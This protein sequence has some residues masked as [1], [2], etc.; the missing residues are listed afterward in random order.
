MM[1]K[2]FLNQFAGKKSSRAFILLS[3]FTLFGFVMGLNQDRFRALTNNPSGKVKQISAKQ[4]AQMLQNKNFTLINVH[5]PY[6][7][8]IE[9]TDTLIRYDELVA[10]SASLPQDK[11]APIVL[12]CKTGRMSEEAIR[13]LSKL[14]FTNVT[15]LT[16]GMDAWQKQGGKLLDLSQIDTDVLPKDGVELPI[17]WGNLGPQLVSLGV[18]DL[19]KFKDLVKPTPD[20]LTILMGSTDKNIKIDSTNSQFVVD[21]L[22]A[23][24]L[25]QKSL[26]YET[27]PMGTQYKKDVGNFA[28]TGGW[29]LSQG[30]AVSHLNQHDII[31]LTAAQQ[32]QVAQIA[33]NIYRPCCGN[34]TWFP[35]CNHGMAALALIEVMV[36]NNIDEATIYRK[37]LGFNSFWFPTSYLS[38]ATY[39]ARLG[40]PWNQVDTKLVLSEEY[41]SSKGAAAVAKKVGPLPNQ[42]QGGSGCSA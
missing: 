24:G 5:T 27:G 32:Q 42:P 30:D 10:N 39:F 31:P 13:I 34:S 3:L 22:W 28:S 8:E 12:Y 35:D 38:I 41:S 23:L 20:Q 36:A 18:I 14:G 6:E 2:R 4:L 1:L 21:V 40:T 25:A 29:T 11:N 7:G 26:A 16:G 17:S 19:A 37:V 33:Q 15:H 9:K